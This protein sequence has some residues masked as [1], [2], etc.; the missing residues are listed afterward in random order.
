MSDKDR[1]PRTE[2]ERQKDTL[3]AELMLKNQSLERQL[4]SLDGA[5]KNKI[6]EVLSLQKDLKENTLRKEWFSK[7]IVSFFK[8]GTIPLP[9][10]FENMRRGCVVN[11][12]C[13]SDSIFF[14]YTFGFRAKVSFNDS[15]GSGYSFLFELKPTVGTLDDKDFT[16]YPDFHYGFEKQKPEMVEKPKP[17]I[18]KQK[19]K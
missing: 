2:R 4:H 17:R 15:M 5:L 9:K 14:D 3:I 12:T 6:D 13:D 18:R 7:W 10:T 16:Q 8:N 11:V 1:E 19:E